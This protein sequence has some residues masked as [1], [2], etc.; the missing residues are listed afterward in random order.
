L[1]SKIKNDYAGFDGLIFW[2]SSKNN[3][4]NE[5][6]SYLEGLKRFVSLLAELEKPVYSLYGGY[7]TAMLSKYGL[8]GYSSGICYGINKHVDAHPTG[9]GRPR[10]YYLPFSHIKVLETNAR[11]FF[12]DYT[13]GNYKLLCKC[14]T[15]EKIKEKVEEKFAIQDVIIDPVQ[16]VDN[17]FARFSMIDL[18][19]HFMDCRH[20]ELSQI[21]KETFAELTERV[22]E[23]YTRC[24]KLGFSRYPGMRYVH[25][26]KWKQALQ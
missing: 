2:G 11:T 6:L 21:S 15:C 25:L 5:D 1:I 3:E 18:R 16:Y 23:E 4:E 22:A 10:R 19:Q 17:F 20:A 14:D 24:H 12:A 8:T 26:D 13:K 9:G 7:F